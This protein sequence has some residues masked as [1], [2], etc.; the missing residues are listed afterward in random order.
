MRTFGWSPSEE[1]L[2]DLVNVIDQVGEMY[3]FM[4]AVDGMRVGNP[5]LDFK[6]EW[7]CVCGW[8]GGGGL[9]F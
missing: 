5:N 8:V 6:L 2:K 7:V 3:F 9:N 1:E 4:C